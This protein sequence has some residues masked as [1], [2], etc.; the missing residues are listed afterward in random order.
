[1]TAFSLS[2]SRPT[3]WAVAAVIVYAVFLGGLLLGPGRG[4][5]A[6][7][8]HL[9]SSGKQVALARQV[10]GADVVVPHVDG[11][12][13]Q[14][15]WVQARDPLLLHPEVDAAHLDRPAYRTQRVAYPALVAPWGVLGSEWLVWGLVL[16]NLALVGVG[17]V[18]LGRLAVDLGAPARAGLAFALSPAIVASVT[19]DTGDTLAVAAIVAALLLLRRERIGWAAGAAAVAALAKEPMLLSCVAVG[20]LMP[21]IRLRDRAPFVGIPAAVA[22]MWGVYA[23]WRLGWPAS[24]IQEFTAPFAGFVDAYRRGWRPV[25][26]Y[27]DALLAVGVLVFAVAVITRWW[28]RRTLLL[29]AALPFAAMVPFFSASVLDLADN[30]LRVLGPAISLFVVDVYAGRVRSSP[31]HSPDVASPPAVRPMQ[32]QDRTPQEHPVVVPARN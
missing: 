17:T 6:W 25:G 27:S 31:R 32:Q 20:L 10:L 11:S 23:R 7:F 22:T 21:R 19:L 8:V 29:A 2:R 18:I 28:Q 5:P 16:T 4:D 26:N 3:S 12:D 9:G 24:E 14:Q 15:F 30:S 13:G 1:M